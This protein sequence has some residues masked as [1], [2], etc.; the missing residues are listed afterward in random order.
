MAIIKKGIY[1]FNDVLS[2]VGDLT[3]YGVHQVLDFTVSTILPY[4]GDKY[5]VV[6]DSMLLFKYNS[7]P[8]IV[9]YNAISSSPD[10]NELGITFPHNSEVYKGA[11]LTSDF[12]EGI[13]T[14]TVLENTE[15]SEEFSKWFAVNA[16]RKQF[17]K[18]NIGDA[19]ITSNNGKCFKKLLKSNVDDF[20]MN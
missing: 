11:W 8:F 7:T 19:I 16:K 3:E 4:N 20:L 13:K 15:V 9:E 17:A 10:L 1:R 5:A 18:L 14:I 12:G 2:G 6:C